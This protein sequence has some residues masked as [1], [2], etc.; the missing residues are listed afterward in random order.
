MARNRSRW[1]LRLGAVAILP[2]LLAACVA[3]P[4]PPRVVG[5]QGPASV[6]LSPNALSVVIDS[7]D[8]G[9]NP[10]L[11]SDLGADTELI[12]ALTL[13]SAYERTVDG[14]M[15][16]NGDLITEVTRVPEQP[17]TLRYEINTAAQW[18][19]GVPI[20][21]EDF[22]YMWRNVSTFPG[23]VGA[24]GYRH[25]T[26]ITAGAGGKSIDVSFDGEYPQWR[27]LFAN[28]LPAHL[29]GDD[30]QSFADVL[31]QGVP[32]SGGPFTVESADMGIG[33]MVLARN[34]RYWAEPP[35]AEQIVVRQARDQGTLGQAARANSAKLVSVTDSEI[36]RLVLDTVGGFETAQALGGDQLTLS[37]NTSAVGLGDAR[38]RS[39]LSEMVDAAAVGQIVSGT[40]GTQ[41]AEFPVSATVHSPQ[42]ANIAGA[43]AQLEELGY[44]RRDGTWHKDGRPLDVTLGVVAGDEAT[45]VAASTVVDNLRAAG[46]DARVWE[47]SDEN[48]YSGALPYGLVSGVVTWSPVTGDPL[49][50]ADGRYRCVP[51]NAERTPS[52]VPQ[53]LGDLVDGDSEENS[54]PQLAPATVT[55]LQPPG[56]SASEDVGEATT[57]PADPESAAT[58][59]EEAES[60]TDAESNDE[61]VISVPLSTAQSGEP[62][63]RSARASNLSGICDERIDAALDAAQ[64]TVAASGVGALVP[65]DSAPNPTGMQI[66]E[67]YP[68]QLDELVTQSAIEVP[69]FLGERLLGTSASFDGFTLPGEEATV[70]P[71]GRELYSTADSWRTR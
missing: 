23:T 33:Q 45:L 56:D 57:T 66:E 31:A 14:R 63:L 12:A 3:D 6:P 38:L 21:V 54:P 50:A 16:R 67:R 46:V 35:A 22:R 47:L 27:E 17:F 4:P 69:L 26:D 37:W 11:R 71:N 15:Q 62:V 42:S 10:H 5:A 9:F 43:E 13:P 39:A 1:P 51:E 24:T 44:V 29:M 60:D 25:I 2:V 36:N 7:L 49:T 40:A 28:L 59:R 58:S 32:A 20:G 41:V 8:Q 55:E 68:E 70:H 52:Q 53:D 19:D 64:Q 61:P 65:G 48:L 34:D 30:A 18:S